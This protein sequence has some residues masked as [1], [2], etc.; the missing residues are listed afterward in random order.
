MLLLQQP[1]I[2]AHMRKL[3]SRLLA[4]PLELYLKIYMLYFMSMTIY[5]GDP[6]PPSLFAPSRRCRLNHNSLAIL[7]TC[8]QIFHKAGS[9]FPE[10]VLVSFDTPDNSVYHLTRLPPS[11]I[12]RIRY[13]ELDLA[14]FNCFL[15]D[16]PGFSVAFRFNMI[17]GLQLATLTV[18]GTGSCYDLVEDFVKF[19]R[20]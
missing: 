9:L 19:G 5:L 18:Y 12:S 10:S 3:G 15:F 20:G 7:R 13:V 16:I 11:L 14:S 2:F 6:R 1:V 8:R 4:L 17:S